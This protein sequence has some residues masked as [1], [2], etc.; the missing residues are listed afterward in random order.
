[1]PS[2]NML[3]RSMPSLEPLDTSLIRI[4]TWKTLAKIANHLINA[5]VDGKLIRT[6]SS[7]SRKLS[8]FFL[9]YLILNEENF[10]FRPLIFA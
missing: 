6:V 9:F 8:F 4:N 10:E 2:V 3:Y 7:T 5:E 1:M